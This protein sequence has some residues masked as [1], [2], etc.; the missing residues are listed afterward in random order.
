MSKIVRDLV[1]TSTMIQL[2][3][4]HGLQQETDYGLEQFSNSNI[5]L[6][7]IYIYMTHHNCT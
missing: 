6:I 1:H 7:Y 4:V 2:E 5:S 3:V